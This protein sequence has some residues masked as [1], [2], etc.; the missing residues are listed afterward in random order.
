MISRQARLLFWKI[1]LSHCF[2]FISFVSQ[3]LIKLA[4][5][6][7]IN[8]LVCASIKYSTDSVSSTGLVML[9]LIN[10]NIS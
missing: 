2:E 3:N 10:S 9:G 8:F 7:F 4:S 6:I 5:L 1:Q